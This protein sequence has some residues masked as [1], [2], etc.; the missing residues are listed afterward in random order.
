LLIHFSLFA[1]QT[2]HQVISW[3][4]LRGLDSHA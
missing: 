1:L 2:R 3:E 4:L